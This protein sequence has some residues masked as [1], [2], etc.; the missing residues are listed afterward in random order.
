MIN[1]YN[2]LIGNPEEKRP[3]GRRER[4]W[5]GY[6]IHLAQNVVQWRAAVYTVTNLLIT[7]IGQLL[8]PTQALSWTSWYCELL[9]V[10]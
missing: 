6:R 5:E 3:V 10:S 1:A 8:Q 2:I 7:T 9:L 4:R